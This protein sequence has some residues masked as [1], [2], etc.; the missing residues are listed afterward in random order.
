MP[1]GIQASCLELC[2]HLTAEGSREAWGL[3]LTPLQPGSLDWQR[4]AGDRE[5]PLG[6][7]ALDK[8]QCQHICANITNYFPHYKHPAGRQ[9][10][11]Q[12]KLFKIEMETA[13]QGCWGNGQSRG[14]APGIWDLPPTG[15][16]QIAPASATPTLLLH[17]NLLLHWLGRMRRESSTLGDK[18]SQYIS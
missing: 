10:S 3:A 17:P 2:L 9:R 7:G 4:E 11:N 5:G 15:C 18:Q 14:P 6:K 8:L 12:P 1:G 16:P 13:A